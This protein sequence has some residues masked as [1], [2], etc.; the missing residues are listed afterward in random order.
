MF[1]FVV[2]STGLFSSE[3]GKEAVYAGLAKTRSS[4]TLSSGMVATSAGLTQIDTVEFDMTLAASAGE[5][6]LDPNAT[7]NSTIIT[8]IDDSLVVPDVVYTVTPLIGDADTLLEPGELI[9]V[10]VDLAAAGAAVQPNESF[11]LEI[12]PPTGSFLVLQ[13]T[14]P[15]AL[16]AVMTLN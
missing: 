10:S 15:P 4:M 8:Y 13:R 14:A 5:A 7:S 6:N 3:R 12:K 9:R 11:T 16:E 1:A 2:L